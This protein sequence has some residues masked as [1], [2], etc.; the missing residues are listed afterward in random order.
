M[1]PVRN[2]A[3]GSP[4]ALFAR[5]VAFAALAC[6][7]SCHEYRIEYH[8]R[9]DFYEK[10]SPTALPDEV[11]LEDGT[12]IKYRTAGAQSSY[13]R[14]GKEQHEPLQIREERDDGKVILRNLLPEH[15]LMNALACVQKQEW[16]LMWDQLLA[17]ETKAKYEEAGQGVN[18]FTE[19][20]QTHRHELA[21][22]LNRMVSG[23][24]QQH[25]AFRTQGAYTRCQIRPQ[26][27]E[28]F[29]YKTVDVVKEKNQYKLL[30]I[31]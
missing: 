12:V 25:V 15:V 24:A 21:A 29:K 16:Q 11:T 23:M 9:P 2:S 14:T 18:E 6:L 20:F 27:A 4:L 26:F 17:D 3:S 22:T 5:A 28:P 13:G 19:F 31:Q 1:K 30:M 7:A 10:A 8:T